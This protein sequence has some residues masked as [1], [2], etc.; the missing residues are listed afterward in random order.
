MTIYEMAPEEEQNNLY[1]ALLTPVEE[2]AQISFSC[3]LRRGSFSPKHRNCYEL[4]NFLG[5]L[6]KSIH[7][8]LFN[9]YYVL[10]FT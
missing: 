6:R 1:N 3:H 5:Y 2:D 10:L 9:N 7:S 8:I 4:V